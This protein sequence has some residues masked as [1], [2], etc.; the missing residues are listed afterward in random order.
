MREIL[1]K[2]L[3]IFFILV[4]ISFLIERFYVECKNYSNYTIFLSLLHH[5]FSVYLYFGTFIFRYYL[6]NIIIGLLTIFAWILFGN[7]CFLSLY[8]NNLCGIDKNVQFHDIVNFTNKFL[9]I[10][11]FHYYILGFIFIYNFYFLVCAKNV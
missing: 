7:R 6:F 9:K 10:D 5:V 3:F 1:K 11:N 4:A 2:K 8:Y